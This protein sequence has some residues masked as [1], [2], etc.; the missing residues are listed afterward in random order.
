MVGQSLV[1]YCHHFFYSIYI[2]SIDDNS[3]G[4]PYPRTEAPGV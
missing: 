3:R 1:G 2:Y 4:R